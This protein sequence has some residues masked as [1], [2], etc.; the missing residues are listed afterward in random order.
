MWTA[1][2][3]AALDEPAETLAKLFNAITGALGH[4][5]QREL[6]TALAEVGLRCVSRIAREG[7]PD[8]DDRA[9]DLLSAHALPEIKLAAE[10]MRQT[11]L[12]IRRLL[13]RP[14]IG[15]ASIAL[16]PTVLDPEQRRMELA[17]LAVDVVTA[18]DY[19]LSLLNMQTG[20]TTSPVLERELGPDHGYGGPD[21]EAPASLN[22]RRYDAKGLVVKLGMRLLENLRSDVA[23]M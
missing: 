14:V 12:S 19:L 16:A 11:A 4:R 3:E 22:R 1:V 5:S 10:A 18:T 17:D 9:E 13:M 20:S 6:K 15:T 2:F 8:L 21:N 23:T 7:H